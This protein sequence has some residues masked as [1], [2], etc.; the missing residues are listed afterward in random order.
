MTINHAVVD[1]WVGQALAGHA[2]EYIPV[3]LGRAM[4]GAIEPPMDGFTGVSSPPH[5]TRHRSP[6]EAQSTKL[7]S[8]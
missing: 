5:P 4:D 6:Y 8:N 2:R 1:R 3:G 7:K